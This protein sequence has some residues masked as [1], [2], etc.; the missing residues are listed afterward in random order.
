MFIYVGTS[1]PKS[2]LKIGALLIRFSEPPKSILEPE[3]WFALYKSSHVFLA[4]PA[5]P[6]RGFFMVNEA[7][8]SGVRWVSE[9]H[10]T[11]HVDIQD[12]WVFDLPEHV[13]RAVKNYGDLMSGAPYPFLENLGIGIQRVVKWIF[14]EDILN[15]FDDNERAIKCS[16]LFFRALFNHKP[17]LD[18]LKIKEDLW[19]EAGEYI[20]ADIDSL[21]VRDTELVLDWLA[22]HGYCK[23]AADIEPVQKSSALTSG[24]AS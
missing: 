11:N 8:T 20:S 24:A 16:E 21:G 23:R 12:L 7:V 5:H 13:Y 10:F 17:E 22:K 1:R 4:Y 14:R 2:K 9:P 6:Q 19:N 18:I 15:P 3:S